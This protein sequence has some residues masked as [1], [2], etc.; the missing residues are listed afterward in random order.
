MENDNNMLKDQ[1][2]NIAEDIKNGLTYEHC[3]ECGSDKFDN[4]DFCGEFKG[5][6]MCAIDYLTNTLEITNIFC[7][8]TEE[9]VGSRILVSYGGPNIWINTHT[10][11][12][13]GYWWGEEYHE[14][15]EKD[16]MD[17]ETMCKEVYESE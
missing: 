1:V 7:E 10:K 15:Y 12:I 13:E 8:E 4:C 6:I 2:T 14:R 16:V 5:R 3:P 17:L 9:Y 11:T